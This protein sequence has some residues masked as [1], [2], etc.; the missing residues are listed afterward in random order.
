MNNTKRGVLGFYTSFLQGLR[1]EIHYES[2]VRLSSNRSCF[3]HGRAD[4]G[5]GAVE[6]LGAALTLFWVEAANLKALAE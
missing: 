6:D 5:S 1:P 4:L 2:L 3:N